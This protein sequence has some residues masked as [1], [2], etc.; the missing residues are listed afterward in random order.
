MSRKNCGPIVVARTQRMLHAL[1]GPPWSDPSRRYPR[2]A[3]RVVGNR[4]CLTD[5][6]A[7]RLRPDPTGVPKIT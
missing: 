5:W 2:G 3:K 1:D 4:L 6:S 7:W